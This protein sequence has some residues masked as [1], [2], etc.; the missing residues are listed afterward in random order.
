MKI[1]LYTPKKTEFI[2]GMKTLIHSFIQNIFSKTK[3]PSTVPDSISTIAGMFVQHYTR[4]EKAK[5]HSSKGEPMTQDREV[6][7]ANTI[8]EK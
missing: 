6:E 1:K 4:G 5:N 2:F 8:Q 7:I 3:A